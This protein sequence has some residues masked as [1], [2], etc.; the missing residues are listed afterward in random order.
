MIKIYLDGAS[1]ADMKRLA[2]SV[3]G[4]TTNPSLLSQAGITNY[5]KFATE[6]LAI[7]D[8]K[9]VSFE[10]LADEQ[11]EMERQACVINSWGDNVWVKIP[12]IDARGESNLLC[13]GGLVRVGMKIN[14]TAVLT[15]MQAAGASGTVG[16]SAG[17][18]SVFAGRIADCCID[19]TPI[20][21]S[22]ACLQPSESL[23]CHQV[24]WASTREV[25]NVVH[26]QEAGAD[27]ITMSPSLFDKMLTLA[28]KDLEAYSRE[29]VQQFINDAK[30]IE[31]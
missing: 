14:V 30:G 19:P 16:N 11:A 13:I 4:F 22:A 18:V 26:A 27:I 28:D 23:C 2:I 24:L 17:I 25:L 29:T 1:L 15:Q 3:D 31:F 10:V 5:R 8:G 21:R 7:A 20:I 9:P 6:V 12:V